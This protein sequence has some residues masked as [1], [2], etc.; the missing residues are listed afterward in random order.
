MLM[1]LSFLVKPVSCKGPL[2]WA[3]PA[4]GSEHVQ[5]EEVMVCMDVTELLRTGSVH[6]WVWSGE[7]PQWERG[8]EREEE[9]LLI[10]F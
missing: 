1:A 4:A 2:D 8:G 9:C 7:G 10:I 5:A 6:G 3:G